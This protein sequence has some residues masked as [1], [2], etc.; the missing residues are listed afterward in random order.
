MAANR[1]GA[2]NKTGGAVQTGHHGGPGKTG[3]P[4]AIRP[5]IIVGR[6]LQR[7]LDMARPDGARRKRDGQC[8][9][10]AADGRRRGEQRIERAA[11]VFLKGPAAAAAKQS[12]VLQ[13]RG[14]GG[15]DGRDVIPDAGEVTPARG[16]ENIRVQPV[17]CVLQSTGH[18]HARRP[19]Q[20]VVRLEERERS[21]P[22]GGSR[23]P[24]E[25][26]DV[27]AGEHGHARVE[28][29]LRAQ[30]DPQRRQFD[31][32][33]N[34]GQ[35]RWRATLPPGSGRRAGSRVATRRL[36]GRAARRRRRPCGRCPA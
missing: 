35:I 11:E 25:I 5:G 22:S 19:E 30:G 6:N 29:P 23:V 14:S 20:P 36:K 10:P 18:R 28:H 32:G 7:I 13:S 31:G 17:R 8:R 2:G 3:R 12:V 4:R 15:I 27:L 1:R 33:G 24:K 21:A 16:R 26:L 34:H 9:R